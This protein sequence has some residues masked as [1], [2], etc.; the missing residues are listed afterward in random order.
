MEY[1][2]K[3]NLVS[4][5]QSCIKYPCRPIPVDSL[6]GISNP[7][8]WFVCKYTLICCCLLFQGICEYMVH[9]VECPS[10]MSCFCRQSSAC[11]R[12]PCSIYER[13]LLSGVKGNQSKECAYQKGLVFH[14][15]IAP[16][17]PISCM[18]RGVK[19]KGGNCHSAAKSLECGDVCI[20]VQLVHVCV[21]RMC[22][23][24]KHIAII[25]PSF[26]YYSKNG[27]AVAL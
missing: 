6:V 3:L 19:K 2:G 11:A 12:Q 26:L 14:G 24:C 13:Q 27:E 21:S 1:G 23:H 16:E 10:S 20:F 18:K 9:S 22:V 5:L 7:K 17:F 8:T 4:I 15:K 25:A